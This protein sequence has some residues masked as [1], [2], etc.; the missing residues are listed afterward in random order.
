MWIDNFSCLY[1]TIIF[2]K[3]V[4][5]EI[6]IT[7]VFFLK[8]VYMSVKSCAM[9]VKYRNAPH[10]YLTPLCWDILAREGSCAC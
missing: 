3:S 6:K 2:F 4:D 9:P 7:N 10:I 1:S 8:K 5:E